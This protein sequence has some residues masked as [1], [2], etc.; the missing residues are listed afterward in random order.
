MANSQDYLR[1]LR[2][3]FELTSV[4]PSLVMS[5]AMPWVW[6]LTGGKDKEWSGLDRGPGLD[7]HPTFSQTFSFRRA[8]EL[9]NSKVIGYVQNCPL[10]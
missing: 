10:G 6:V 2:M 5:E 8:W 3:H 4:G 9:L 7:S 1:D